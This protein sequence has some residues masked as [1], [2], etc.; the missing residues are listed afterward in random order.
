MEEGPIHKMARSQGLEPEQ[1]QEEEEKCI[2][3]QSQVFDN[4]GF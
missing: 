4:L 2:H 3:F 1:E